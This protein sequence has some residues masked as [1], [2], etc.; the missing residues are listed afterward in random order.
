MAHPCAKKSP[1]REARKSGRQTTRTSLCSNSLAF[2]GLSDLAARR[3]RWGPGFKARASCAQKPHIAAL[4][5]A[6]ARRMR[7]LL[8]GP[9]RGRRVDAAENPGK[10]KLSEHRDVRVIL[11]PDFQPLRPGDFFGQ[12]WPKKRPRWGVLLFGYFLLHKQEKVTRRRRKLQQPRAAQ[13]QPAFAG[14]HTVS[15]KATTRG[16]RRHTPRS[17]SQKH[18][19]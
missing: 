10:A 14:K 12:G 7:A 2:P 11:R 4:R 9:H 15:A 1:S 8:D 16:M 5:F 6:S 17:G 3:P 19:S 13:N 18:P